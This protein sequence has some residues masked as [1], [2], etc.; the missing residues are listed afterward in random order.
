VSA[1]FQYTHAENE[2]AIE[3]TETPEQ[4]II[5][6]PK[7]PVRDPLDIDDNQGDEPVDVPADVDGDS[8]E[9][10]KFKPEIFS[11]TNYDGNPR[12]YVQTLRRLKKYPLLQDSISINSINESLM[13]NLEEHLDEWQRNTDDYNGIIRLAKVEI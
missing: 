6:V 7:P 3:E 2:V 10:P 13:R 4:I 11:W 9:V 5:E 12:D 8:S 1:F